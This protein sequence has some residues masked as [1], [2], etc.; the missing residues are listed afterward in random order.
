[1]SILSIKETDSTSHE[2][3]AESRLTSFYQPPGSMTVILASF[4]ICS[5]RTASHT[6]YPAFCPTKPYATNMLSALSSFHSRYLAVFD[7]LIIRLIRDN[8]SHGIFDRAS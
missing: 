6:I 2:V 8:V 7:Y 3:Y 5:R 1:M 4:E